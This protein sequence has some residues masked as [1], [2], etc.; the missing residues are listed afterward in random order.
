MVW[1]GLFLPPPVLSAESS[2]EDRSHLQTQTRKR[3]FNNSHRIGEEGDN[4]DAGDG[5]G[6]VEVWK[7]FTKSFRQ[8]QSVLDQNRVLIQQVNENHQSKIPHNL[9]KNVALIQEINVNFS[10]VVS[11]YSGL[12]SNFSNI[13]HQRRDFVAGRSNSGNGKG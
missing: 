10:K 6:D 13:F 1:F 8:V 11:L 9:T 12:S 7:S 3:S 4:D 5:D 2:M